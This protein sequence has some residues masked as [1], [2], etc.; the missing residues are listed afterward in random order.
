MEGHGVWA[1]P[2]GAKEAKNIPSCH[3]FNMRCATCLQESR[4]V[5]VWQPSSKC[6]TIPTLWR[7]ELA[8]RGVQMLV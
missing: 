2:R 1:K 6:F 5:S 3:L 4:P 8:R 7:R